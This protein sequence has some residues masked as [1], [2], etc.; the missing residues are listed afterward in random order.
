MKQACR[1][2]Y[3]TGKASCCA[4]A[5]D[6][7][8]AYTPARPAGQA[9]DSDF[10]GVDSGPLARIDVVKIRLRVRMGIVKHAVRIHDDFADE[11]FS[12]NKLRVL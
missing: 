9:V 1:G 5:H 4:R 6:D 3:F 12:R 8:H 2:V 7:V 10:R 11:L